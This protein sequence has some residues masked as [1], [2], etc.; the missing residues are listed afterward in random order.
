[1]PR[2][3][4]SRK[5]QEVIK[6]GDQIAVRVVEID[7]GKVRLMITAPPE[8]RISRAELIGPDYSPVKCDIDPGE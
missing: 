4:L 8:I 3:V 6:L 1:M 2:L 7:R 5:N